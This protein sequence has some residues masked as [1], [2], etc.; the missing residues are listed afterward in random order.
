MSTDNLALL[1]RL[2]GD[3]SQLRA[4]TNEARQAV[5]Q[6]KQSMG[7]EL[8]QT[9]SVANKAFSDVGIGL[10]N[11][12]QRIPVV[13]TAVNRLTDLLRN[14]GVEGKTSEKA[15]SGIANSISNIARESGKSIPQVAQFL[16]RFTQIAGAAERDSAAVEFFGATLATKLT[17]QLAEAR[18]AMSAVTAESAAAGSAIGGLVVPIGAALIA[19]AALVA[20]LGLVS[21]ELF[22]VSKHAA[23]FQGKLQDLS[24]QTGVT[25]ET[26]ST[27]E[28]AIATT[29]GSLN[30][31]TQALVQFQRQMDE[32]LDP[33]SDAAGRFRDLGIEAEDTETALRQALTALARMPEGFQQTNKAAELFGAR[34]GK[35]VLALLKE[36][37]GDIDALQQN[38][39]DTGLLITGDAARAADKFN[40]ELALLNFQLRA[41][42]AAI[43]K[44][45]IPPLI[46]LIHNTSELVQ[47]AKPLLGLIGTLAGPTVRTLAASLRGAGLVVQ[48]LTFD[49]EGLRKSIR[50]ARE[51]AAKGIPA[52]K[53]ADVTTAPPAKTDTK[54]TARETIQNA[55][56]VV[57]AAKRAAADV[58]QALN[59]S[60]EKGR[61][62]RQQQVDDTIASN[63][64]VLRAEK[65]RITAEIDLE[66]NK[67]KQI[68]D[69]RDLDETERQ[70]LLEES[71][72]KV[73]ALQQQEQDA[74]S[75][76]DITSRELR[77]RAAKERADSIRAERDNETNI[78][79]KEF[80]RQIAAIEAR[81]NREG[82]FESQ[83]LAII[84][85]LE[86]AKIDARREGLE[87]Q[88][89]IGFLTVEAQAEISRQ[90]QLVNQEADQLEDQQ[91]ARREQRQRQRAERSRQLRLDELQSL[92][93][94]EQISG[95][96]I[97][98]SIE[99]Q[100]AL[101][102]RTE[103]SAAREILRIR[104]ALIDDEREALQAALVAAGSIINVD[105]RLQAESEINNRLR[106]LKAQRAA[107]EAQGNRAIDDARQQDILNEQDYADDLRNI[108]ER[109][110]DAQRDAADEVIRL[111]IA[112]NARRRDIIRAERELDLAEEGDR[113]QRETEKIRRQQQ[114][115]DAE[116]SVLE[117]RLERLKVG[118]TEEIEE[119]DRLIESL[120]RLRQK[121]VELD[122]QQQAEDKRSQTRKRRVVIE[123][124]IELADP[125][126]GLQDVFDAIGESVTALGGKF[127]NLI[128]LGKEF[129][130]VSAQIA[131]VLGGILT[132]AFN[133]FAGAL[134][135]TAANWVLLGETG[136]AVMRKILAQTLAT[137][138]AEAAVQSIKEL[139]LGFASLFLNPA[140]AAGHF[141]AAGLWASIAGGSALAGRAVA[142]D[143]FKPKTGAG[144]GSSGNS[145]GNTRDDPRAIDLTRPRVDEIHVYFHPE[146]GARFNDHVVRA[147]V[148]DVQRNGPARE[149]IQKTAGG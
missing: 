20:G 121:R 60:F 42:G 38:L 61:I 131:Q 3:A 12:T 16:T 36:V 110:V 143:L 44:D 103:E 45:L 48:A 141:T 69:R 76:F 114:E 92:L 147:V 4:A 126:I 109:V 5:N 32:S 136:P 108:Q 102:I 22:T 137:I 98:A 35:Q 139:A 142:G 117:K 115:T 132:G 47:A 129:N 31:V 134:G 65:A 72:K 37:N 24:Q 19:V 27:L 79:T 77:A 2:K 67:W 74:Q 14:A 71:A 17:P 18:V 97:I 138:A 63:E 81:I 122:A 1:F 52:I 50:E 119:H 29:G 113:H 56:T 91:Q 9:V 96:S 149:V 140:A 93:E 53:V 39:R 127:A 86:R 46:E 54:E 128:G 106:V 78:L 120:E 57:A 58:N 33:M 8:A 99:A 124:D 43:A 145:T 105:E 83:G 116:I 34:G 104:L 68:R 130:A 13:G 146:P 135:Q 49:F 55:E 15:I 133:Q 11:L 118:T 75:T 28:V 87:K 21:R 59:E 7:P 125:D 123:T 107:I 10:G 148:D 26:L 95:E 41:V 62:N 144:A 100:A 90:I 84:E 51:E 111:M 25:V 73:R 70:R 6:L 66:N 89:Q 82:E 64:K 30:T 88:K 23:E 80:D 94:V 85:Q 101:R 112:S 40:D